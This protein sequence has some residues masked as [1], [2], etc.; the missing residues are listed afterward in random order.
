YMGTIPAERTIEPSALSIV[1]DLE[2]VAAGLRGIPEPRL[3]LSEWVYRARHAFET[4]S[5][6]VNAAV[7]A[8]TATEVMLNQILLLLAWEE[9]LISTTVYTGMRKE[10]LSVR[11]RRRFAPRLPGDWDT[12]ADGTVFRE[13]KEHLAELRHRVVHEGYLPSLQETSRALTAMS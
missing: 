9:G 11:L 10:S 1:R 2:D 6:N 4:D 3:L 7:S 12:R 8:Y 5:D 13:W